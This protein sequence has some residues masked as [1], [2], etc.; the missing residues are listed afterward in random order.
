MY[1]MYVC[2]GS[3]SFGD[4]GRFRFFRQGSL[5]GMQYVMHLRLLMESVFV[6][7]DIKKIHK[8]MTPLL[9][10]NSSHMYE[11]MYVVY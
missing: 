8:L 2:E 3:Y 1:A 10:F 4:S 7:R 9:S 6:L 11:C 5:E